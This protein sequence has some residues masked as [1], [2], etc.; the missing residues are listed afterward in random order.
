MG[1]IQLDSDVNQEMLAVV[2]K[3]PAGLLFPDPCI[4]PAI[5]KVISRK[6][7]AVYSK[8]LAWPDNVELI[9]QIVDARVNNV[10]DLASAKQLQIAALLV[11]RECPAQWASRYATHLKPILVD[12][13][14]RFQLYELLS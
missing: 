6:K 2:S 7:L 13:T 12:P 10:L 5:L 4:E 11:D 1:V 3:A 8:G 14:M 9:T